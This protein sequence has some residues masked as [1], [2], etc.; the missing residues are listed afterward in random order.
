MIWLCN[1]HETKKKQKTD[2]K[3][4]NEI[5]YQQ[6]Q[7][8][9]GNKNVKLGDII[10]GFKPCTITHKDALETLWTFPSKYQLR[11]K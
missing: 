1:T 4:M 3:E 11:I 10:T 2:Y 9:Y 7:Y 8:T 5:K 6:M